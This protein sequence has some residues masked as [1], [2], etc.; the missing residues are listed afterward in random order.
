MNECVLGV[1]E[2]AP[3]PSG[4]IGGRSHTAESI[5]PYQLISL[6][7]DR[8]W[9]LSSTP[10]FYKRSWSPRKGAV[11]CKVTPWCQ[12]TRKLPWE[13]VWCSESPS[14][15]GQAWVGCELYVSQTGASPRKT[16]LS[17]SLFQPQI[18]SERCSSLPFFCRKS[19]QED[20]ES[21]ISSLSSRS[22][23][24]EG[25]E[26]EPWAP[27]PSIPLVN[28]YSF[29]FLS[30]E[31]KRKPSSSLWDQIPGVQRSLLWEMTQHRPQNYRVRPPARILNRPMLL[32]GPLWL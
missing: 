18:C 17:S 32:C 13:A 10:S 4:D 25:Q 15:G 7:N 16:G 31:I 5:L 29:S 21:E 26:E 2:I 22:G 11:L 23:R 14:L 28:I 8:I 27:S 19:S 3:G 20:H 6:W 9:F 1:T 12:P 30:L 24:K